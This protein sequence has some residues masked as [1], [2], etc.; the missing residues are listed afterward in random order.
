MK[1]PNMVEQYTVVIITL[2]EN[3]TV[4]FTNNTS[5]YGGALSIIQSILTFEGNSVA[6]FTNN[7]AE[8]GGAFNVLLSN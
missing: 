4:K 1:L 6:K 3:V 7:V 2:D 8:R 5:E